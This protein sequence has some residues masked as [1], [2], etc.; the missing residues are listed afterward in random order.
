M[1]TSDMTTHDVDALMAQ[2]QAGD[3][4]A[5]DALVLEL[6]QDVAAFV[7]ARLYRLDLVDVVVQD[8]EGTP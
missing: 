2:A 1:N 4:A 7:V 8:N 3:G 6:H 5:F